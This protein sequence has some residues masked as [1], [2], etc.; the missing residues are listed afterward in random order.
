MTRQ[1]LKFAITCSM[2]YRILLTWA[3]NSLESRGLS[4]A[5][6]S[7]DKLIKSDCPRSNGENELKVTYLMAIRRIP[8]FWWSR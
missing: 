3:F 2:T 8:L 4:I 5:S 7:I 1:V 6:I